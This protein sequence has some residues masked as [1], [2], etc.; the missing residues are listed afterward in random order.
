[1]V[2]NGGTDKPGSTVIRHLLNRIQAYRRKRLI[3]PRRQLHTG[4]ERDLHGVQ[5]ASSSTHQKVWGVA[6]SRYRG[7]CAA[8]VVAAAV[9]V[10]SAANPREDDG[11]G[12][13]A[14]VKRGDYL[15]NEVAHCSHCHSPPGDNG[16]PDRG[17]LLLGAVLPI[18][19]KHPT[20]NW[21]DKSP[22]ITRSGLAGKWTETDLVK[23]LTTGKNPDGEGPTPPMPAFHLHED[24]AR[25]VAAYLRSLPGR[26]KQ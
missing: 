17:R 11:K 26:E 13:E 4:R 24:D 9:T 19:P 18:Q 21:A 5:R 20:K 2:V 23:F 10:V 6:M 12:R 1:M 16:L 15:V 25:A 8:A 14:L 22:D 7:A 3:S